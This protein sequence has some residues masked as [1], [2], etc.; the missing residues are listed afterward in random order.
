MLLCTGNWTGCRSLPTNNK[1]HWTY[2]GCHK[3]NTSVP[4]D[5]DLMAR[6]FPFE[7]FTNVMAPNLECW[8]E[9]KVHIDMLADGC[10]M[11]T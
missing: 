4:W 9:F 11:Q 8:E 7:V 5:N 2:G 3:D 1:V 10:R 6:D